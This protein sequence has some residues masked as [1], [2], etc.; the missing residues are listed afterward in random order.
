MVQQ[1]LSLA[2]ICHHY[3]QTTLG[4]TT[5]IKAPSPLQTAMSVQWFLLKNTI[6]VPLPFL[7]NL[8]KVHDNHGNPITVNYRKTQPLNG[9]TVTQIS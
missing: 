4:T 7:A 1:F 6:A 2:F 8:K 9:R 3:C 5:T